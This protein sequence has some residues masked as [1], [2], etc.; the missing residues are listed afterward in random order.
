[1]VTS[2]PACFACVGVAVVFTGNS[3]VLQC[4][5]CLFS[6]AAELSL[7]VADLCLVPCA[8]FNA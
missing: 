2:P 5:V 6:S 1:M 7:M 4:V 8:V 3:R